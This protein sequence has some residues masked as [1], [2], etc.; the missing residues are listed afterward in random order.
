MSARKSRKRV[1]VYQS[2]NKL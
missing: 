1:S 2:V